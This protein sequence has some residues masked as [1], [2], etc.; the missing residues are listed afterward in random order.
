VP[1]AARPSRTARR[2]LFSF[3]TRSRLRSYQSV[4]MT[5]ARQS[6]M[7][8][9]KRSAAADNYAVQTFG[10]ALSRVQPTGSSSGSR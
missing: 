1:S 2:M 4:I 5:L 6:A 7:W 10:Q 9:P 3:M 8:A